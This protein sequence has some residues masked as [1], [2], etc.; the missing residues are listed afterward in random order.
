MHIGDGVSCRNLPSPMPTQKKKKHSPIKI[1]LIL[2][3]SHPFKCWIFHLE[4]HLEEHLLEIFFAN[5]LYSII[6]VLL[7]SYC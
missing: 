7:V 3:Q 5:G 4:E 2:V 1:L 6:L